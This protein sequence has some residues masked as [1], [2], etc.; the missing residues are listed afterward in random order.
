M[1]QN[2]KKEI[3]IVDLWQVFT[4]NVVLLIVIALVGAIICGAV[5]GVLAYVNVSYETTLKF[6]VSPTDDTDALLY[7]LQSEA[8]AEKL[9][10]EEKHPVLLTYLQKEI[11][12][13][14]KVFN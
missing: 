3:N 14:T 1:E 6:S 8:F 13:S 12:K 2:T 7:N 9:L 4:K 5:G 11:K 10:L